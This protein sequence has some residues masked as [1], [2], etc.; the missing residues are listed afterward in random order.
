MDN[1]KEGAYKVI[2]TVASPLWFFALIAVILFLIIV[3]L[4]WQSSLDPKITE[5]IIKTAFDLLIC[6]IIVV[7]VLVVFFQEN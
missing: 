3:M 4:D 5:N 2:K 6:L 1:F 7:F